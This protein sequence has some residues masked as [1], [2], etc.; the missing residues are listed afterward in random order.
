MHFN[1][2]LVKFKVD[3]KVDDVRPK[4]DS[5]GNIRKNEFIEFSIES[6]LLDLT[7]RKTTSDTPKEDHGLH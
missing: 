6:K 5:K 2:N 1:L 3:L 4:L 7:D